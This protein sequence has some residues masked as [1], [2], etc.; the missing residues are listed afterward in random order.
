MKKALFFYFLLIW[1]TAAN[2]YECVDCRTGQ[3]I[4]VSSEQDCPYVWSYAALAQTM[5][6]MRNECEITNGRQFTIIGNWVR[7]QR[8]CFSVNELMDFCMAQHGDTS[9]RSIKIGA[10]NSGGEPKYCKVLVDS[11]G[12]EKN[13][14]E[15]YKNVAPEK[16]GCLTLIAKWR[17]EHGVVKA[18]GLNLGREKPGTYVKKVKLTDGRTV[19]RVIDV[20]LSADYF[21][22]KTAHRKVTNRMHGDVYEYDVV[23]WEINQSANQ[24]DRNTNIYEIQ[25]N[26][27][28]VPTGL[29]TWTNDMFLDVQATNSRQGGV[30]GAVINAYIFYND[31]VSQEIY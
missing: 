17:L 25:G 11:D 10:T 2:A 27:N 13:L 31:D 21:V 28:H 26:G 18:T 6:D 16:L 30:R 14:P 1:G 9:L 5:Q 29:H 15:L 12:V 22:S 20:V 4:S 3:K 8:A 7:E 24:L 23:S 19:Y